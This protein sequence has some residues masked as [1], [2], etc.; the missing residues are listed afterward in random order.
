M[1][2]ALRRHAR[3]HEVVVVEQGELDAG[4]GQRTG[5]VR[6]P[7]A[8]GHPDAAAVGAE[9]LAHPVAHHAQLPDAVALRDGGEDRLVKAAAEHLHAPGAHQEGRALEP[10]R[11]VPL[12]PLQQRAGHVQAEAELLV[13]LDPLQERQ[14]AAAVDVLDDVVEVA[15]RLVVVDADDEFQA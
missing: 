6:L 7:D 8:L 10:L 1:G 4:A 11:V 14:V 3:L 13:A 9:V 15:D 12:Q 2:Q 5:Q